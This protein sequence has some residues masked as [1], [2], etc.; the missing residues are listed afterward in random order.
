MRWVQQT[1]STILWISADPGWGKS[2]LASFLVDH[3]QKLIH[4]SKSPSSVCFFFFKDN[5]NKQEDLAPVLGGMLHQLFTSNPALIRHAI[6]YFQSRGNRFAEEFDILWDIL[7][8]S[9]RDDRFGD[10]IFIF[11]GLDEC[12]HGARSQLIRALTSFLGNQMACK[13][14]NS[15]KIR[16]SLKFILTS[17]PYMSIED[18]LYDVPTIRLKAEEQ[19]DLI[20]SDIDLVVRTKVD[21]FAKRRQLSTKIQK[22]ITESLIR[23]ADKTFLWAALVL[24]EIEKSARASKGALE[25]LVRTLPATLPSLYEKILQRASDPESA[26]KILQIVAV[27]EMPLTLSQMNDAFSITFTERSYDDFDLEPSIGTTLRDICGLFIRIIDSRIYF[28]HQTAKEFLLRVGPEKISPTPRDVWKQ[29]LNMPESHLLLARICM[30]YLQLPDFNDGPLAHPMDSVQYL[31]DQDKVEAYLAKYPLLE[32]AASYWDSHFRECH[33]ETE[34]IQSSFNL[35]NSSTA[36]FLTWFN[37]SKYA[38]PSQV[39]WAKP[40]DLV[41]RSWM[42]HVSAASL[43]SR[44]RTIINERDIHG[45]T[46]LHRAVI[47]GN[48]AMTSLLLRNGSDC[49]AADRTGLTALHLAALYG[50]E[51]ILH[52]LLEHG[53]AIEATSSIMLEEKHS[54]SVSA[55]HAGWTALHISALTGN[56][57]CVRRLLDKGANVEA[58][59][60][61]GTTPLHS[62]VKTG[63]LSIAQ[64]L[65]SR[66]AQIELGDCHNLTSTNLAA[67]VGN[68]PLMEF[69]LGENGRLASRDMFG[70]TPLHNAIKGGSRFFVEMLINMTLLN[71]NEDSFTT[72]F[73]SRRPAMKFGKPDAVTSHL[74]KMDNLAKFDKYG[75]PLRKVRM[76]DTQLDMVRLLIAKGADIDAGND[77]GCTALHLAASSTNHALVELLIQL[78]A[79]VKAVGHDGSSVLHLAIEVMPLETM[80]FLAMQRLSS[81]N[82]KSSI[83][84]TLLE[85]GADINAEREDGRTALHLAAAG[86]EEN[87]V[88]ILLSTG[89]CASVRDNRGKSPLHYSVLRAGSKF[90]TC[91]SLGCPWPQNR[92]HGMNHG[93]CHLQCPWPEC[94]SPHSGHDQTHQLHNS[95]V[96]SDN[97]EVHHADG[98]HDT[99]DDHDDSK[100]TSDDDSEG[101]SDDEDVERIKEIMNALCEYGADIDARDMDG[102]TALHLSSAGRDRAIVELLL[103]CGADISIMDYKG[104]RALHLAVD[105]PGAKGF[106]YY[107]TDDPEPVVRSLVKWGADLNAQDNHGRIALHTAAARKEYFVVEILLGQGSRVDMPD[108]YGQTALHTAVRSAKASTP[109]DCL[110]VLIVRLILEYGANPE[111]CDFA[112]RTAQDLA[113]LSGL[114]LV[115]ELIRRLTP[116]WGS[117]HQCGRRPTTKRCTGCFLVRLGVLNFL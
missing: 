96:D 61:R 49:E 90:Q 114:E 115:A 35:C 107:W 87:V 53:A 110:I 27:A 102:H 2:V 67:F 54:H 26:R 101:T 85:T 38:S 52:R 89:A 79:N 55:V 109:A 16:Q 13:G 77:A 24:E 70:N 69:L 14:E 64:L 19:P 116:T 66:G 47:C 56:E 29:S 95:D 86:N 8:R 33:E 57:A 59:G 44:D 50:H 30:F 18:A 1:K 65:V 103:E 25:E 94:D 63:Y 23:N 4:Q 100:G 21:E 5:G 39:S 82:V 92:G 40:S 88:Q 36:S 72:R 108:N 106:E 51:L 80:N 31:Q 45:C 58:R 68:V 62:A 42:G 3:F 97:G 113:E 83:V 11:D 71:P 78:G 76:E 22:Q 10:V 105:K 91:E 15:C 81:G 32:Y 74:I 111:L 84:Y 34:L 12:D 6:P 73:S 48:E 117:C 60:N 43:L 28:V 75:W 7:S 41:L 98:D 20:K 104:Q 9:S 17:R 99:I 93:R 112:G 46:A 37:L